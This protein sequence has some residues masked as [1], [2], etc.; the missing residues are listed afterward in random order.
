MNINNNTKFMI[1]IFT[2]VSAGILLIS[3]VWGSFFVNN[4]YN[5]SVVTHLGKIDRVVGEGL[6]FKW[7]FI[8]T[9]NVADLR[10]SSYD[11]PISVAMGGGS[12]IVNF[13]MTI[14]HQI[15]PNNNGVLIEL[16]KQ[17]GGQYG[18]ESR[19][20]NNLAVD[21]AKGIISKYTIEE[22][23]DKKGEIRDR[24]MKIISDEVS[25][26]GIR[27]IGVQF[28]KMQFTDAFKAKLEKVGAARAE[29]AE[30]EQQSRRESFLA[31][32]A[33][34][35]SRGKAQSLIQEADAIAYKTKVESIEKANAI[36]RE[37]EANAD[38]ISAQNEAA[39]NAD[40]LAKLR[41]AEA[42]QKWNGTVPQF[43]MGAEGG[44]NFLPF[45]NIKDFASKPQAK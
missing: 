44:G 35:T 5:K 14:N 31:N 12:N 19:I 33:I 6:N 32:K 10:I 23:I 17:F 2:W 27:I 18:Y 37:G 43:M 8:E 1:K 36:R 45:M 25:R 11:V 30:A 24:I 40:G 7:P 21:R 3:A 26:F 41:T 20:L 16:Y 4:E 15:A 29:A 38:A 28:S 39:K 42:M 22:Y 34:E 13:G 9:N